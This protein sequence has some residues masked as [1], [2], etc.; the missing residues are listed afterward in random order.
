VFPRLVPGFSEAEL[1]AGRFLAYGAIAVAGVV[2]RA[3]RAPWPTLPQ[4]GAAIWMSVLGFTGYYLLLV[5]AIRDAGVAVP[6]L[7]IGTIPI[8]MML[9]G[10]PGHLRWQA[11]LP[12]LAFTATGLILMTSASYGVDAPAGDAYWRGIALAV[13]SMASWTAFGMLN[14]SWL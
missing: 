11:L 2:V 3:R 8:W 13:V 6:S 7:I 10:K 12:G 5:F 1:T 14:A 9:L 4:A